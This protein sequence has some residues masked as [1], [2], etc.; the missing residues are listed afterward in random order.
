MGSISGTAQ[1]SR[2]DA[3]G[4][5][6]IDDISPFDMAEYQKQIAQ[7]QN[8][9]AERASKDKRVTEQADD[10]F[11]SPPTLRVD[12]PDFAV[13]HTS[14]EKIPGVTNITLEPA[15]ILDGRVV[16]ANSGKP[17]AG[18]VVQIGTA[19]NHQ[20]G[21]PGMIPSYHTAAVRTI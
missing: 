13:K 10:L 8:T 12:H 5:Y 2:T 4:N 11:I 21:Y 16:F 20:K 19:I 17:A 18:A 3:E 6:K 14:F 15:A 7:Q 1:S 9:W